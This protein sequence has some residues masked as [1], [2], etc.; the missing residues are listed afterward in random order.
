MVGGM[1]GL[2]GALIEGPRIGLFDHSGRSV[3]L[4]G[5][6]KSLVVLGTLLWFS[7][8]GFNPGSFTK[9][10]SPYNSGSYYGQ[11][12]AVGW[13]AMTTTFA[14]ST[15]TLTALFSKQILSGH[16]NKTDICNGLLGGFSMIIAGCFVVKP[17]VAIICGFMA[18]VVL[19]LCNQLAEK[20]KFD[21]PLE[22]A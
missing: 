19:I 20:L 2:W 9:I 5:H 21:E 6:N 22:A 7:W 13:I 4:R 1:A 10:L 18:T 17:W 11:W 15:G 8:Y 14:R 12:S 16:W 3:A